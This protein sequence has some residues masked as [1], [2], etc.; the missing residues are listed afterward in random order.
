MLNDAGPFY[1]HHIG[2]DFS[3]SIHGMFGAALDKEIFICG[4]A[5]LGSDDDDDGRKEITNLCQRISLETYTW[6][7]LN[8]SMLE[9]RAFAQ[10]VVLG[11]G[12]LLVMGGHGPE[13][14]V[15]DTTERFERGTFDFHPG[16]RIPVRMAKHC[17]GKINSSY[18]FI[19]GGIQQKAIPRG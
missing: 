7:R 16:I 8:S 13:G 14:T 2:K 15:L 12:S 3:E 18:S 6:E 17:A 9:E 5:K 10:A 1:D 11:N 19:N 4:G